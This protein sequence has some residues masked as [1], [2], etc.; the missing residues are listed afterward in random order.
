[1][2]RRCGN[3]IPRDDILV[4]AEDNTVVVNPCVS[5]EDHI[6]CQN[7]FNGLLSDDAFIGFNQNRCSFGEAEPPGPAGSVEAEH[8]AEAAVITYGGCHRLVLLHGRHGQ[9]LPER[10]DGAQW[11]RRCPQF[12]LDHLPA[13]RVHSE[14][15]GSKPVLHL[16]NGTGVVEVRQL[17]KCVVQAALRDGVE[18]DRL[19]HHR[20]IDLD[21]AVVDF[22]VEPVFPPDVIGN[23]MRGQFLLNLHF[24]FHVP[25]VVGLEQIPLLRGVIRQVPGAPAVGF[26]WRARHTEVTDQVLAFFHLLLFEAERRTRLCQRHGKTHVSGPHHVAVPAF[27]AEILPFRQQ[28][29]VPQIPG[30]ADPLEGCVEAR[31]DYRRILQTGENI[32]RDDFALC[33]IVYG[34]R[35]FVH[36]HG[37]EQDLERRILAVGIHPGLRQVGFGE[38]LNVAAQA[39]DVTHC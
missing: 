36:G 38:S 9:L 24:Y 2:L 26:R 31:L 19:L 21:P 30:K 3:A 27:R 20:Q 8:P 14:A 7:T 29:K 35:P 15:V 16:L 23:R 6:R 10:Q 33:Q 1:M 13:E 34:D 5:V 25:L 18:T 39:A 28:P 22:L 37:E 11:F 4:A 12:L 32:F 17:L